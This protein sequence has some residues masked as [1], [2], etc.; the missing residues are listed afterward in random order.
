MTIPPAVGAALCVLGVLILAGLVFGLAAVVQIVRVQAAVMT[1]RASSGTAADDDALYRAVGFDPR[2][3][4]TFLRG[5]RFDVCADC[6]QARL[7][8]GRASFPFTAIA[9]VHGD[10]CPDP[11]GLE[12]RIPPRRFRKGGA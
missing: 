1:H 11:L 12:P 8:H 5:E 9:D 4:P 3:E 7:A 10:E 6:G 2:P